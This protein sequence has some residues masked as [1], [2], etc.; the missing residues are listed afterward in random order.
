ME[1]WIDLA[2]GPLFRIS[3]AIC[4]LGLGYRF[5]V[6]VAQIANAWY[7]AGDRDLPIRAVVDATLGWL[8]PV[9]LLRMRPLYSAASV[10]FHVGI[11]LLPLFLAGH[12]VLLEPW[13]PAWFLAA[14]PTLPPLLADGLTL[15]TLAMLVGLL[16]GRA[17]TKT[18][19]A[20]SRVSDVLILIVLL[21]VVGF[22]FLAANP[23]YAPVGART[24]LLVHILLGNLALVLAPVSKVAHCV[25]FPLTQLVFQVGWHFPAETGRHVAIALAKEKESV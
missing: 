19:R 10:L 3:L 5:V 17:V 20:L 15:L 13:L 16:L 6:T 2:R 23:T 14:W 25:L 7:R 21:A 22:G 11:I 9:G 18:A 1:A 12:V 4:V 8:F 24:M